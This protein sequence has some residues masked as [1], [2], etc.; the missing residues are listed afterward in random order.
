RSP[1]GDRLRVV[2][3]D[4][5]SPPLAALELAAA[6]RRPALLFALPDAGS[7]T[8]YLGGGRACR[9]RYDLQEL[10]PALPAAGEE[11]QVARRLHDPAL[12]PEAVLG[13]IGD[14]PRFDP[15][16][17]LAF[18]Q[19]PGAAIEAGR[20]EW[21]RPLQAR[22]SAEGLVRLRLDPADV[23]RARADL[24][25]LRIA[26]AEGRQ[27][28]YLL[29][30]AAATEPVALQVAG[31][32]TEDGVSR[33]ELTPPHRPATLEGLTLEVD[34]PF[35][36]RPFTLTAVRDGEER[37]LAGGRLALPP[38]DPRPVEVAFPET[39][40]DRLVLTVEDGSDAPLAIASAAGRA[41]L[42]E[43]YFTAPAGAYALLL[44]NPDA[45]APR[46]ELARVRDVVL[47]V[48][49]GA[50]EA[51]PIEK[52]P[53]YR[54]GARWL[55]GSGLQRTLLWAALLLAVAG[56]AVLTLRLARREEGE[57]G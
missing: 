3:H 5:D 41:P 47:A 8:V 57:K 20:W 9:P 10:A 29:E 6:I 21:R 15:A 51:G 28:A 30:E 45:A 43:L 56:L 37:R 34:A 32:E 4:G 38:R 49:A 33:Y 1:G 16:P 26:D 40:L 18:A 14:N 48:S 46:Y 23:A 53:A 27:W 13:E 35:F 44:G 52:N 17:A 36:D 31:P 55:T 25:D 22:P 54:P 42:P 19:R 12:L 24:A 39:R 2:I 50:A 11:A 7:A